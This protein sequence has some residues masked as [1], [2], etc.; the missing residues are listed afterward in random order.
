M[1]GTHLMSQP[2]S[3]QVVAVTGSANGIG[4]ATATRFARDGAALA[5]IDV[6]ADA[7]EATAD[8]LRALGA[9]VLAIEASVVDRA[10]VAA[11]FEQIHRSL[12]PVDVLV[13][14]AGQ[15]ARERAT[16]FWCS[17]P[18]VWDFVIDLSLKGTLNCTRQVVPAMR[19]R[20]SGRIV[21]LSSDAA[22][23]GDARIADY[24]AAKAGV[25]GFSRSLA[26]ELGPFGVTVNFVCPG[27]TRTRMIDRIPK[28]LLESSMAA[29]PMGKMCEPDDIA[30]AIVFLASDQARF[31][32]GQGLV[33]N[34]GR[35][36]Y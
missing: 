13:N 25:M 1:K 35:S 7:L 30:N 9:K 33:V 29:I 23:V 22:I 21:S 31:I 5:L 27:A 24:A 12:G 32:T 8:E 26:R 6:E 14:N 15:T 3:G 20:R 18:E 10:A 4:K 36:F 11:A 2:F 34:G 28:E 16:E 17:D 19:E